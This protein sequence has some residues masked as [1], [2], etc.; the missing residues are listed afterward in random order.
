MS[1]EIL[2]KYSKLYRYKPII[3]TPMV[4]EEEALEEE[5]EEQ[6]PKGKGKQ[7]SKEEPEKEKKESL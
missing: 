3:R 7:K 1:Q 4:N 6:T 2:E 5:G